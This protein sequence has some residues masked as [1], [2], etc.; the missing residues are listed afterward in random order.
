V[1]AALLAIAAA[2]PMSVQAAEASAG[3]IDFGTFTP[4]GG[5]KEF[6]EVNIR[7]DL[8]SMAARL[9]EKA[10]P[11][12]AEML[13]GIRSVRV[14][15]VGI[16]SSNRADLEKRIQSIRGQLDTQG[17]ERIVTAQKADEDVA[18]YL[19]TRGD[20]AVEGVVVTVLSPQKEAVFVNVVGNI[21]V[22]KLAALGER[23][24]IDPLK[25]AGLS[26]KKEAGR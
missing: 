16:D 15:V 12:V 6:V 26:V 13:R 24:G 9:A 23:F 14:N 20:Q 10:E 21:Q 22:E 7:G 3:A 2:H 19:K 25:E 11:Q 4:P 8:L 18:V 1:A 17:W 5:G